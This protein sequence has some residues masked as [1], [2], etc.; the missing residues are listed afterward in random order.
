LFE[1]FGKPEAAVA[2]AESGV[3]HMFLEMA[4]K[5]QPY[6]DRL[7]SGDINEE[8]FVQEMKEAGYNTP[9]RDDDEIL[10]EIADIEKNA[11]SFKTPEESDPPDIKP[12]KN[13]DLQ[14][15][16]GAASP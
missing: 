7:A 5:W 8:Q 6:V 13:Y 10:G 9:H 12:E 16:S 15:N 11:E 3:T 1:H 14:P 4:V 2:L